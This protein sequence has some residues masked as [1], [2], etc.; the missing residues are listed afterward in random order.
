MRRSVAVGLGLVA[1]AVVVY[2]L[3]LIF[4]TRYEHH[5]YAGDC[6]VPSGIADVQLVGG[7][8]R[9]MNERGSPFNLR[10]ELDG[11]DK[12]RVKNAK[13]TSLA[14][15]KTHA[16]DSL[17]FAEVS[18]QYVGERPNVWLATDLDLPYE[19]YRLSF[20]LTSNDQAQ[21]QGVE[22]TIARTPA[23]EWTSPIWDA[24]TH[25]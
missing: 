20:E 23:V 14:D 19:D 17:S 24:I 9:R 3:S 18:G 22:C 8:E 15:G 11:D 5:D 7:F 21:A 25:L 2:L 6:A 12:R 13:L 1:T 10:I 4:Y 16:V